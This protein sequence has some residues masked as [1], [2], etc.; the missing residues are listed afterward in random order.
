MKRLQIGIA[1]FFFTLMLSGCNNG[2]E[3]NTLTLPPVEAESLMQQSEGL[4]SSEDRFLHAIDSLSKIGYWL[5]GQDS[6]IISND[7]ADF[8]ELNGVRNCFQ[9]SVNNSA[10]RLA[11]YRRVKNVRKGHVAKDSNPNNPSATVIQI[12]FGDSASAAAWFDTLSN[13]KQF[14]LL[15]IK[16]KTEVWLQGNAVYFIQ[17]YRDYDGKVLELITDRFRVEL[18]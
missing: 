12:S 14:P 2:G 11:A 8:V 9:T 5:T 6:V 3:R 13:S 1:L 16:P 10:A 17:S 15:K 18:E 4:K 7:P